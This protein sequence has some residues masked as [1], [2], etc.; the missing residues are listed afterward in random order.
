MRKLIAIALLLPTSLVGQSVTER[1]AADELVFMGDEELAMRR[2]FQ[3][4]RATLD[5][6]LKLAR[7]PGPG[8]G[9][10]S[11]KV[12]VAEGRNTECFWV[13]QFEPK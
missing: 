8:Q 3:G 6:F 2:A 1:A 13:N 9:L 11:L 10:F 12:A 4:A 7:D 5:D